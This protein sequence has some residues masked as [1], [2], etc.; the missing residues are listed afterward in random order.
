MKYNWSTTLLVPIMQCHDSVFL[1]ISDHH[2]SVQLQYVTIWRYYIVIDCIPH[3]VHFISMTGLF[4]N[5][6][7]VPVTLLQLFLSSPPSLPSG[8]HLFVL[9]SYTS[10]DVFCVCVCWFFFR[11]H[12]YVKYSI[13][14]EFLIS[15]SLNNKQRF[16]FWR[17][18]SSHTRS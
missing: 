1:Y 8:N 14:L 16:Y 11:L 18:A 5:W 7:L 13:C 10:V 3:T 12:I 9:Y 6:N 15:R 2:K 17:E 4:H